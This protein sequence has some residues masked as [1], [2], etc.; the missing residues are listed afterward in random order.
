MW[1]LRP[2]SNLIVSKLKISLREYGL[3]HN[4]I[5]LRGSSDRPLIPLI[6]IVTLFDR[7]QI[8]LSMGIKKTKRYEGFSLPYWTKK[9]HYCYPQFLTLAIFLVEHVRFSRTLR[10]CRGSCCRWTISF[11]TGNRFLT[12]WSLTND[13]MID[14]SGLSVSSWFFVA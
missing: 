5:N 7:D 10:F 6:S 8:C 9:N 12:Y 11:R 3:N 2:L 4:V 1:L 13:M 14:S